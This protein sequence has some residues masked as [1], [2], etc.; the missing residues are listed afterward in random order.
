MA[1]S[2]DVD[3]VT[4]ARLG[5]R[6]DRLAAR[7]AGLPTE[8][9]ALWVTLGSPQVGVAL[10]AAVAGEKAAVLVVAELMA[11]GDAARGIELAQGIR[12]ARIRAAALV[13]AAS[14]FAR[15]RPRA[16]R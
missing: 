3:L 2:D 5:V 14:V 6:A 8:L 11:T 13:R 15:R 16:G 4:L 12:G 10:A 7:R 1:E 9:P